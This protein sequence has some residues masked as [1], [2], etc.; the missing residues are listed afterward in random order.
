MTNPPLLTERHV[1]VG[2]RAWAHAPN[3]SPGAPA[4]PW[5]PDRLVIFDTE[6]NL[7]HRQSLVVGAYAYVR[8]T[9]GEAGP[10][11]AVAEEGLFGSDGDED[12]ARILAAYAHDRPPAVSPEVDDRTRRLAVMDRNSFVRRFIFGAVWR[13]GAGL[14]GFNVSF[15]LGRLALAVSEGRKSNQGSVGLH[16][17][18]H[19]NEADPFR[20]LIYVRHLDGRRSLFNWGSVH[21]DTSG[22]PRDSQGRPNAVLHVLDMRTL[23]NALCG[24]GHTLESACEVFGLDAAK[25]PCEWGVLDDALVDHVRADVA[26]TTALAEA[27]LR[28]LWS[29]NLNLGPAAAY[30]SAG[31]AVAMLRSAGVVPPASRPDPVSPEH[32][33]QAA[34]AFFGPRVE[35]RIRAVPVPVIPLDFRSQYA[36]VAEILGL[37]RILAAERL[38]VLDATAEVAEMLA[39]VS[40]DDVLSPSWWAGLNVIVE[41]RPDGA[42]LPSR[43]YLNGEGTPSLVVS[44]L[45]ADRPMFFALADVVASVLYGGAPPVL[46]RAWRLV[47][48]GRGSVPDGLRWATTTADAADFFS[49]MPRLRAAETN[50]SL[51]NGIKQIANAAAAGIWLRDD[52][53]KRPGPVEVWGPDCHFRTTVDHPPRLGPFA[54]PP[55]ATFVYAGGRLLMAALDA[56]LRTEGAT[57]A[58][59]SVD[60]AAVVASPQGGLIPCPSGPERD[61][62]D[63]ASVRAAPA[64]VVEAVAQ[65]FDRLGGT[66]FLRAEYPDEDRLWGLSLG[67]NL[68]VLY[69]LDDEEPRILKC[70]EVMTTNLRPPAGRFD[71]GNDS[72]RAEDAFGDQTWRWVLKRLGNAEAC[73]PAW[74]DDPAVSY[75]PMSS[76]AA[77]KALGEAGSP[78]GFAGATSP[79]FLSHGTRLIAPLTDDPL[80]APWRD[81]RTGCQWAIVVDRSGID[82][83]TELAAGRVTVRSYRSVLSRR[84]RRSDPSALGPGERASSAGLCFPP[85]IHVACV[86]LVGKEAARL[87]ARGEATRL[88]EVLTTYGSDRFDRLV[89]PV[90]AIAGAA[91][92]ARRSGLSRRL[93]VEA[94]GRRAKLRRRSAEALTA[95][96]VRWAK[97]VLVASK[98]LLPGDDDEM[99]ALALEQVAKCHCQACGQGLTGRQQRWCSGCGADRHAARNASRGR[100]PERR[101]K[102]RSGPTNWT[103]LRLERRNG[104]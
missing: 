35:T 1:P 15:D 67:P 77:L 96:A 68:N 85:A 23:V 49:I 51:A 14:G 11:L 28:Y 18:R 63:A 42:V 60:A 94:L 56:A 26:A 83:E 37:G 12:A 74:F 5:W 61:E 76:A 95:G 92:M 24:E 104:W 50:P 55:A 78:F 80:Y 103:D 70:S 84:M 81:P 17:S 19:G 91:E 46:T 75:V 2:L 62:A 3:W 53:G 32:L 13:G 58:W 54:F 41:M 64:S 9:Y 4:A 16:L 72:V 89:L 22:I 47:P 93:V 43:S 36:T 71:G 102:N 48:E 69:T 100:R 79:V 82:P 34:A 39:N 38:K 27:A 20:P 57:W 90:A 7:D 52:E 25:V 97:D 66:G 6:T 40:L 98:V 88:N 99:M 65:R 8:V 45:Y 21:P 44:P 101:R 33:G 73:E 31:P 29:L 87:E 59:C 86:R 10:T 30:S